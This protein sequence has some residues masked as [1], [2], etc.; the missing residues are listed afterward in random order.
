MPSYRRPVSWLLALSVS[1]GIV[2]GVGASPAAACSCLDRSLSEYADEVVLAFVGEQVSRE[3]V[4]EVA[5]NGTVLSFDVDLVFKGEV[6]PSVSVRTHAQSSACGVD[7]DGAVGA[8][9]AVF[10][11]RG[12]PSVNSCGSVVSLEELREVFGNGVEPA[13]AAPATAEALADDESATDVVP[14]LY[15]AAGAMAGLVLVVAIWTLRRQRS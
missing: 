1:T 11:W 4:D 3:V 6:G 14:A 8:S 2:F 15:L 9:V 5:D 10:D 12:Q 7:F 13:R